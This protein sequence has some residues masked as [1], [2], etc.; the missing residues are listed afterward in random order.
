MDH[1]PILEAIARDLHG[2]G[3]LRLIAQPLVAFILG[4]KFGIADAEAAK[5]PL[6]R[7]FL[8]EHNRWVTFKDS[9]ADVGLPFAVALIVD[10][11][12]QIVTL[13]RVYPVAM[14]LVG[15]LLVWLPFV[16]TRG[17]AHRVWRRRHHIV[18]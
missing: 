2:K 13:G 10:A 12:L 11:C 1:L 3:Q 5:A 8:R 18:S 4:L 9:V 7:R 17:L 16:V 15:G 6:W 14:L